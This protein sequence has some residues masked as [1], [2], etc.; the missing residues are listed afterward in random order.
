MFAEWPSPL[1]ESFRGNYGLDDCYLEIVDAKYDLVTHGRNL[2][3]EANIAA[4]KKP[5]FVLRPAN[6]VTSHDAE[7]I[8]LLL[9]AEVLE[10]HNDYQP[11]KGTPSVHSLMGDLYLPLDG[12]RDTGAEKARL[13][14]ELEKVD[15]EISKVQERLGNPAFTQKAPAKTLAEHQQRLMEWQQ[16]RERILAA[17]AALES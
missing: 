13:A 6:P 11:P 1:E 12:L 17:L 9:N 5:R 16:K 3:R 7:V 10:L 15:A 4:N 8:K 2:R 14:K